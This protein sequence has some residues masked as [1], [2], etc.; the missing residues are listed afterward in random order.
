MGLHQILGP[1]YGIE[2]PYWGPSEFCDLKFPDKR[3]QHHVI[4]HKSKK[5]NGLE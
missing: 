3:S 2:K 4:K 5:S 1:D